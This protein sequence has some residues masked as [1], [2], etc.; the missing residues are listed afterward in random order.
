MARQAASE[1]VLKPLS[2]PRRPLSALYVGHA[3]TAKG[4]GWIARPAERSRKAVL[5]ALTTKKTITK[6]ASTIRGIKDGSK[7]YLSRA[8]ARVVSYESPCTPFEMPCFPKLKR[9]ASA[10]AIA[11][12]RACLIPVMNQHR[13]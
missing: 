2:R 13:P 7:S 9:L 12:P 1:K 10:N 3:A 5:H 4:L 6:E 11:Y 8:S